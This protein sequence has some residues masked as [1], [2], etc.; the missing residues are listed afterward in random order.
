MF[1]NFSSS[2]VL[3]PLLIAS[4]FCP[5]MALAQSPSK[6]AAGNTSGN[7]PTAASD[8]N[9]AVP[10][11][12][13]TLGAPSFQSTSTNVSTTTSPSGELT[14][15]APPAVTQ[16]VTTASNTVL[17][18]FSTGTS[19]QQ[20]TATLITSP[21]TVVNI[22]SAEV[23]GQVVV[24]SS[25]GGQQTSTSRLNT[26]GQAFDTLSAGV[27]TASADTSYTLEVNGLQITVSPPQ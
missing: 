16:S 8:T 26:L 22:T 19:S 10:V 4:L 6:G 15:V 23:P 21:P 17:V 18:T 27:A 2:W 13:S 1:K 9:F 7:A 14:V 12:G 25:Q 5:Q 20:Q 24:E 11:T 3:S